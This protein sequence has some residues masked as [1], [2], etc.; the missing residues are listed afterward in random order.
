MSVVPYDFEP[1][2]QFEPYVSPHLPGWAWTR[3][4]QMERSKQIAMLSLGLFTHWLSN[5]TIAHRASLLNS[6]ELRFV[7]EEVRSGVDEGQK[8]SSHELG[9]GQVGD[10]TGERGF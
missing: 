8:S 10:A 1:R 5:K 6:P 7:G 2:R 4:R 9:E 3:Y